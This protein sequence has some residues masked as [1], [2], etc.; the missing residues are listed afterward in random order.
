M[1]RRFD[2][3]SVSAPSLQ[4]HGETGRIYPKERLQR[5][6]AINRR[7]PKIVGAVTVTRNCLKSDQVRHEIVVAADGTVDADADPQTSLFLQLES[8][9][10]LCCD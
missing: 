6:T 2:L 7:C 9:N 10:K 5:Q 1:A 3:L 4:R 8:C